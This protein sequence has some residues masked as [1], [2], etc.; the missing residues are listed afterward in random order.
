MKLFINRQYQH[1]RK[2]YA[3]SDRHRLG[4]LGLGPNTS[5]P[6][7]RRAAASLA[8]E[9]FPELQALVSSRSGE[10]LPIGA[11]TAVQNASF[12]GRNLDVADK[13]WVAPDAERV[14]GKATGANDLPVVVAPPE[15]C[16]LGA[17]I[18]AVG[19]G[20]G[21]RIPEVD[22]TVIRAPTSG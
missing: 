21:C 9:Y 14:I 13:S 1:K 16:D 2:A 17:S 20:T 5:F 6:R 4:Q 18:N 19:S 15:A 11:K 12:V 7:S 8:L 10:H 22:V 3:L